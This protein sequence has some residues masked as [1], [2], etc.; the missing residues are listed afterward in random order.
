MPHL[1]QPKQFSFQ[2]I[3]L[4]SAIFFAGYFLLKCP[5][6]FVLNRH[7]I[8]LMQAYS[9][10]TTANIMMAVTSVL[11]SFILKDFH[12]QKLLLLC[13]IVLSSVALLLLKFSSF[14]LLLVG[15]SCYVLGGSL[16]F[17]NIIIYT[18]KLFDDVVE[19]QAGNFKYQIAVNV[20]AFFGGI[21]FITE[22]SE[23]TRLTDYSFYACILA[24]LI[25]LLCYKKLYDVKTSTK[26]IINLSV[27]LL[28]I[29]GLIWLCLFYELATRWMA[30]IV[31]AV[32]VL[33]G[34]YCSIKNK[35]HHYLTL[36]LLVL[37]FSVPYWLAYTILYNEFFHLLDRNT[38]HFYGLRAD[39]IILIDAL[40][41]IIFGFG[42]LKYFVGH[43]QKA[44][45]SLLLGMIFLC[46]SFLVL[47]FGLHFVSLPQ[48]LLPIYPILTVALFS[49]GEFL[50]QSTLNASVRNLL[51]NQGIIS[52]SVGVLRS[53][54]ACASALGYFLMWLTVSSDV[55]HVKQSSGHEAM[56]YL[57][58]A[59]YIALSA[60]A[61]LYFRKKN[62]LAC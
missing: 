58:T 35:N 37:F 50:I 12:N 47:S 27:K 61:Y 30:L 54:R 19:R 31:F 56:L 43:E 53:S 14:M 3:I 36:I 57:I 60:L 51:S 22:Y 45:S 16:Y 23:N 2:I 38:Y 10:S 46:L 32:A 42:V 21:L 13:G 8:P 48:N 26:K 41:N 52:Y 17:F 44:I 49:C 1:K 11:L 29:F 18:N 59:A 25:F 55:D 9:I 5:L 28:A 7:H 24:V 62:K 15:V 20:G 4:I 34:V 40:A 33:Y 39:S 6:A